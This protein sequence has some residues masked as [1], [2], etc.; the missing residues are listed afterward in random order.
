MKDSP[1]LAN[2]YLEGTVSTEMMVALISASSLI[3]TRA[4][5]TTLFEIAKIG[6][7]SVIIPIPEDV[8]RDQR[9]NAYAF[10]RSGA[11]TVLEEKNLGPNLL[12]Q[13]INYTISDQEKQRQM[14]EAAKTVYIE[15]SAKRLSETLVSIG[16]E[17]GS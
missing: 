16:I 15:G 7:P 10:A 3:V 4:G 12:V 2:Y 9:A 14:S 17:H 6:K 13:E 11:A 1:L 8:S 5:S